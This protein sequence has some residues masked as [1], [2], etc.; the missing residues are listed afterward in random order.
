MRNTSPPMRSSEKR[1]FT[2][3]ELL[4]VIAIIGI[5]IALLLPA[6]QAARETARR[7]T[8]RNNLK[9]IGVACQTH[10]DREKTFPS[11]GWGWWWIGDPDKGYGRKQPGGWAYSILPGLELLSLHEN[12]KGQLRANKREIARMLARTPLSVFS[13]PSRRP[14]MLSAHTQD[15][16]KIANNCNDNP[17]NDNVTAKG[18][19]AGCAGSQNMTE[20]GA[21][22]GEDGNGGPQAGWAWPATDDLTS[23][24][25][26]NGLIYTRSAI[27]SKEVTRGTSHTI[28][29][30]EKYLNP[31]D[32]L[33]GYD[34]GDN[35][36]MFTGQNNDVCRVT[37]S[38]PQR[39]RRSS[40][41]PIIFGSPHPSAC[42]FVMADG[43]VH[44]I[45][46]DVDADAYKNYGARMVVKNANGSINTSFNPNSSA[47]VFSD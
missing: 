39:D 43:S 2:L 41:N 24:N 21:G 22:P 10:V 44:G 11:G 32:Y 4:V 26:Q 35:E 27:T 3:V 38:P 30:G 14:P 15:G 5:L 34:A 13:C 31:N 7:M 17:A 33:T 8:C 45:A 47:P 1:G 25:F 16:T 20:L 23:S 19:Y 46:Y 40:A 28:I 29:A 9:Q 18:D 6:I 12:G 36:C 42:H 37:A